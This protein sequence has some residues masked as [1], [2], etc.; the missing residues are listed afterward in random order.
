MDASGFGTP[1]ACS[2][3]HQ[4][5]EL[6]VPELL[7]IT[8]RKSVPAALPISN[9]SYSSSSTTSHFGLSRGKLLAQLGAGAASGSRSSA[10]HTSILSKNHKDDSRKEYLA[11]L[12][13]VVPTIYKS[14]NASISTTGFLTKFF[15][16][17]LFIYLVLM[18][19]FR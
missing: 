10:L 15:Q 1:L 2:S 9:G 7:P 5:N 12:Q 17:F 11:L 6:R 19:F 16:T 4:Q 14:T 13:K 18:F 3:L 8:K